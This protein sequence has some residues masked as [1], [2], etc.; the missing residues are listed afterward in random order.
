MVT[1]HLV[2]YTGD[3][4]QARA[5]SMLWVSRW[6]APLTVPP[7]LHIAHKDIKGGWQ[8]E[9]GNSLGK[10]QSCDSWQF[11]GC[12]WSYVWSARRTNWLQQLASVGLERIFNDTGASLEIHLRGHVVHSALNLI[13]S[14]V[15]IGQICSC[16]RGSGIHPLT[17]T[18]GRNSAIL[19]L[20]WVQH[21]VLTLPC[22]FL[23]VTKIY[24]LRSEHTFAFAFAFCR[25][26]SSPV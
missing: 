9:A 19:R 8:Q 7:V 16:D 20:D 5:H 24:H 2:Q 21:A 10:T 18:F 6:L 4:Q 22:D 12:W 23:P 1:F 11:L 14:H 17:L 13:F 26:Y 3:P 15:A 25:A